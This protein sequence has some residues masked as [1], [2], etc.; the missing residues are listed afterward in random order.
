METTVWFRNPDHYI[1]EL[2]DSGEYRIIWNRAHLVKKE[3]E[4]NQYA[5]LHFSEL[6]W[7]ALVIGNAAVHIDNDHTLRKPKAVYP[8][9]EFARDDMDLLEEMFAQPQ[10]ERPDLYNDLSADV[11]ERPVKDQAHIIVIT[12]CP[13]ASSG[14]GRRFLRQLKEFHEDYPEAIIHI[15]GLYSYRAMF[16]MGFGSCDVD[17]IAGTK[18]GKV[19]IPPGAEIQNAQMVKHPQWA[20]VLGFN[21]VDLSIPRN[22]VIFNIKSACWAAKFWDTEIAVKTAGAGKHVPDTTTPDAAYLPPTVGK[23]TILARKGA[24]GDKIICNDCSLAVDCLYYRAD[25][26]CGVPKTEQ[27]KLA[28]F[29]GTRNSEDIIDGLTA[30][31]RVSAERLDGQME[32]ER[33]LGDADPNVTKG[34][35]QVFDQGV[36]LAKLID[37]GLR[38]GPKV[39]VNVGGA[40]SVQVTLDPRQVVAAAMRELEA[41][42]VRRED[43]TPAMIEGIVARTMTGEPPRE[44]DRAAIQGTVIAKTN[45]DLPTVPEPSSAER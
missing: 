35:S 21:P 14:M 29:F 30:L 19:V 42:G 16:G 10:G 39:Q 31:V 12:E 17:A 43:I 11:A 41:S 25:A 36:K 18:G 5:D 44:P 9:W 4:P 27:H 33:I 37:P 7:E 28:Q 40:T 6:P 32:T 15:S 13:V 24:P 34:L 20:R 45:P 2:V 8:V 3:I 1:R 26:N 22:R 23:H 38:G